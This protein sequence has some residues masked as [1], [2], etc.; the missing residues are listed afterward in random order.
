MIFKLM[1]RELKLKRN[2]MRRV[3]FIYAVRT[4]FSKKAIKFVPIAL[5]AAELTP[6]LPFIS[7]RNVIANMS[8]AADIKAFY[9]FNLSAFLNTEFVVQTSV[10]ALACLILIYTYKMISGIVLHSALLRREIAR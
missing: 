2:I 1:E 8:N 10:V 5:V 6:F 4:I 9:F 3:Y 7:I